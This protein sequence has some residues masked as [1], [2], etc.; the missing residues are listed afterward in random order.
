MD[1]NGT[2]D[3]VAL[4]QWWGGYLLYPSCKKELFLICYGPSG[5]G[6]S[7]IAEAICGVLGEDP[8]VTSLTLSQLCAGEK[9]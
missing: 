3:A 2:N 7:T 6:K 5:T 1:A 8:M 4:L 9:V